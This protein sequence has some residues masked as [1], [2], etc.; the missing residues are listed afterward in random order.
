MPMPKSLLVL[1]VTVLFTACGTRVYEITFGGYQCK[2]P[3]DYFPPFARPKT[4]QKSELILYLFMPKF[5]SES[6]S[7]KSQSNNGRYDN[8]LTAQLHLGSPSLL[9]LYAHFASKR[10]DGAVYQD[11]FGLRQVEIG[12][13]QLKS[14]ERNHLL[15]YGA[16]NSEVTTLVTCNPNPRRP[17]CEHRFNWGGV[18]FALTYWQAQLPN[19]REIEKGTVATFRRLCK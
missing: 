17:P 19:W 15:Y 11:A 16:P 18:S 10:I 2:I 4:P 9:P 3:S 6:E 13:D 1:L 12:N 7:G 5:V 8:K 14:S